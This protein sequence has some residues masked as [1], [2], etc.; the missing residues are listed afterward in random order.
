M[1]IVM[2][3]TSMQNR[4]Q[5]FKNNEKN[6]VHGRTFQNCVIRFRGKPDFGYQNLPKKKFFT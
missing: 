6:Q 2:K 3:L 4:Q 1:M 5:K